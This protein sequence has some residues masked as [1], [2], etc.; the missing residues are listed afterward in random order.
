VPLNCQ[1]DVLKN[2]GIET[3]PLSG[4]RGCGREVISR[5]WTYAHHERGPKIWGVKKAWDHV[6]Q[7]LAPYQTVVTAVLANRVRLDGIEVL[8]QQPGR[9]D[10]E[11]AYLPETGRASYAQMEDARARVLE[12][13]HHRVHGLG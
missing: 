4:H 8:G 13:L 11:L 6:A 3:I 1:P 5:D 2:R 9:Q 7:R 12:L 10:E